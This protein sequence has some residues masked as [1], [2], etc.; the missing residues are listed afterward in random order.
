MLPMPQLLN[1]SIAI[2]STKGSILQAHIA[3]NSTY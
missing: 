2:L 3:M 1:Q